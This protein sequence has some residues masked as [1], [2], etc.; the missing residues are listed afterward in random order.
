[1]KLAHQLCDELGVLASSVTGVDMELKTE[2]SLRHARTL[3]AA[4]QFSQVYYFAHAEL[5]VYGLFI[6]FSSRA[7]KQTY[8]DTIAYPVFSFLNLLLG[9]VINLVYLVGLCFFFLFGPKS[10]QFCHPFCCTIC[11]AGRSCCTF[12]LLHVSQTQQAG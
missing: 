4:K 10:S 9:G 7:R 3:L 5:L 2:A 11:F 6:S 1:M 12:P 8:Q